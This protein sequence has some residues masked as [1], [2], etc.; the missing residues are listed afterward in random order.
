[1]H[2]NPARR[3]TLQA[4]AEHAGMVSFLNGDQC[5]GKLDYLPVINRNNSAVHIG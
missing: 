1:M 3:W 5:S 4:M 2:E